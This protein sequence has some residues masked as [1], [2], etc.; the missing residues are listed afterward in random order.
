MKYSIS[1]VF[2]LFCLVVMFNACH[3]DMVEEVVITDEYTPYRVYEIDII[4]LISDQDGNPLVDAQIIFDGQAKN[5][6]ELGYF[7]FSNVNAN[8]QNSLL[9]ISAEGFISAHRLITV[10]SPNS[11][12]LNVV[13]IPS[14]DAYSF[15]ADSGKEVIVSDDARITFFPK[16]ITSQNQSYSGE[17]FIRTYHLAKDNEDLFKT[18]PGDLIGID[19]EQELQILDTYGMLY[20]TMEDEQGNELQPDPLLKA[21]LSIDI[22]DEFVSSAPSQIPLWFF[23]EMKGVWVEDGVAQRNGNTYEGTVSHFSWWNIDI[24]YGRLV[25]VCLQAEDISTGT[26][27]RNQD[28]LFSS[29]GVLFGTLRTNKAGKLCLNLPSEVEITLQLALNCEHNSGTVI[30][31]FDTNQDN[32]VIQLGADEA[33]TIN[34]SGIIKDCNGQGLT[35]G[36]SSISR[37]GNRST[38]TI[39]TDGT[40]SYPV[41]CPILGETLSMLIYDSQ[42]DKSALQ[43]IVINNVQS[44]A[45]VDIEVCDEVKN[46]VQGN[47]FGQDQVIIIDGL[48][49]NPN[50]TIL[51]L[52]ND[53]YLSFLGTTTGTYD[54]VYYCGLSESGEITVTVGTYDSVIKGSFSGNNISGTFS[55]NN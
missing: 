28:I 25:T 12:N 13:L 37:D 7:S 55:V 10:L 52:E 39:N 6:N 17:V 32:V 54:G 34:I 24:P 18:L 33:E 51:I 4:G 20:V 29:D 27:L 31:P 5:T 43:D 30:G 16:G 35:D 11:I 41:V 23:D 36:L 9:T 46:L 15:D 1:A 48:K 47:I 8:N 45:N 14:P 38:I 3:E 22:P 19:A 26:I 49:I 21:L 44:D 50:E 53:C 42:N 40:Y 2:G